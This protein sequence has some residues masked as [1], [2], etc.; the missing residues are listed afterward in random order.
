MQF[1]PYNELGLCIVPGDLPLV[2]QQYGGKLEWRRVAVCAMDGTTHYICLSFSRETSRAITL[3]L[4]A[5][6]QFTVVPMSAVDTNKLVMIS[7][8]QPARKGARSG[9]SLRFLEQAVE[10]MGYFLVR[11]IALNHQQGRAEDSVLVRRSH[12][13]F[14]TSCPPESVPEKHIVLLTAATQVAEMFFAAKVFGGKVNMEELIGAY[15]LLAH[16]LGS[17]FV[18]SDGGLLLKDELQKLDLLPEDKWRAS[19]YAAQRRAT[20]CILAVLSDVSTPVLQ[21]AA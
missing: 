8:E 13:I 4:L 18:N 14:G 21:A 9:I 7:R 6:G 19:D 20:V 5:E 10:Y 15:S 2:L 1:M 16:R 11:N 12:D 3:G 17:G